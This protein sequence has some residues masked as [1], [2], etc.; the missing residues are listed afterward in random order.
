M[1]G[2]NWIIL[3]CFAVFVFLAVWGL[4]F[5]RTKQDWKKDRIETL[6]LFV[7]TMIFLMLFLLLWYVV[8]IVSWPSVLDIIIW[9]SV[10]LF[11]II[12]LVAV[13]LPMGVKLKFGKKKVKEEE[14]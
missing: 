5:P 7:S 2:V 4:K 3:F 13:F 11:F 14:S 12:F 10:I 6:S 8:S 1:N 9:A